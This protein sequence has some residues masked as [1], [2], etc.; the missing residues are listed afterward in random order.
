MAVLA[1]REA[2]AYSEPN[3]VQRV[4]RPGDLVE[5]NDPCVKGREDKFESV[6]ANAHRATDRRAGKD[7]GDGIIE[8]ATKAPGEKRAVSPPK[9]DDED[10]DALRAKAEDAG[11]KVDKRWGADRLYEEIAAASKS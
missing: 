2:F 7:T 1:C 9:A 3:G 4:L 5:D 6:E 10:L 11:V 8:Q